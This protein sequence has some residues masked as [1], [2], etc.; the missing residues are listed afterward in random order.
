MKDPKASL[1]GTLMV[2][3]LI[4]LEL[5]LVDE[6]GGGLG[7]LLLGGSSGL[8]DE[9]L[10]DS[11]SSSSSSS[12]AAAAGCEPRKDAEFDQPKVVL[13]IDFFFTFY[14]RKAGGLADEVG[15]GLAGIG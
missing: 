12:S 9:R 6:V 4:F 10:A 14:A 13:Y 8:C 7:L 1:T 15:G 3:W 5:G 11:G 2:S